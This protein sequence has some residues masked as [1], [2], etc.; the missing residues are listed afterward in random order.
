MPVGCKITLRGKQAEDL[1]PRL[2]DA[3][4]FTLTEDH[5]D[6]YGSVSFG[7]PEYI[8]IRDINYDPEIGIMGLQACITLE[9]PGYRVK[10]RRLHK[11]S[12]GGAHIVRKED[13]QAFMKEKFNV[14]IGEE[15]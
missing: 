13:A 7:I 9:R 4:D 6:T 1:I 3:R 11:A 15:E 10:R 12:I 14:R 2:L 5:F 8:D